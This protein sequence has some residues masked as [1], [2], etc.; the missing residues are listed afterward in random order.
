MIDSKIMETTKSILK[1]FGN[2]YFSDKGALKRNKVIEDL[3]A[4]TPML[5]KALLANDLIHDTYTESVSIDD[6]NVEIFKLNQFIEMFTYKEYWQDSYTKFENKI[7]LTAGGKFIDETADVVLDFP[8][9]D[10]VLKAGMTKEDQKEADEPFLHET[11][12]K[13]EIDQLL[14]PKIFVNATKYDQENLD[15]VSTDNFDDDNLI[16]KG[17]NLIALHS[18]KNRFSGKIKT[19]YIDPPYYFEA[20]KK[21]DTF[22]YNS[23]FKLSTWLVFMKNRLEVARDLLSSDGAIF[24]QISDDGVAEVHR[25]LKEIFN[26]NDE[27]NFINKITVKTKSP[28]GFASVNAGVFETAEYILAFAKNKKQWT[29]NQQFVEASYDENYKFYIPNKEESYKNWKILNLFDFIAEKQGFANKRTAIKELGRSAFHEVVADFALENKDKVFR[30]TAIGNNAGADIVKAR[31]TS[32]KFPDNIISMPREK[33]YDVYI[34]NGSEL[35]FYSKKVRA[36]DGVDV[37][38]IQLSNIWIDVPYEGIAKEGGVTLKGG[39]KPE[40]L[41]RRILEMSSNPGDTV[42]DFHLGSGTTASVAHKLQRKYIGLEQLEIQI[43]DIKNRLRHVIAG[44]QSGISKSVNWQGGRSFVY[45]ELMEKN[46]GYLK[47]VQHAETTKQLENV[48]NRMITDGTDF[49]FRVDVEK[50]LQDSEYQE[51]LLDDKKHLMV[52]LIDKNQLYYAYSEMEDRDVQE[53]MSD[54]DIAFNK[55]FY[56]E[57]DL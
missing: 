25:L 2:T 46:Q 45:A 17:N 36:I 26:K 16:I 5:M 21:E 30:Y 49:D 33:Y 10:T 9:K 32:K 23:N 13:A 47:D 29:Y 31:D 19:I 11:I 6:K 22:K 18:L 7:G 53:L 54:S 48:V 8:F 34:K 52:K 35:S 43:V 55:S 20:N 24:V 50:V 28:S 1:D 51:M 39:K 40:K 57:R 44:E 42:L 41:I 12:A 37:P 38:S 4:Y 14:E 56:G 27:N 3:D 15:G